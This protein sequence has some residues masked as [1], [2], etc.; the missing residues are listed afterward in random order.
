MWCHTE[1]N[2]LLHLKNFSFVKV[3]PEFENVPTR[4]ILYELMDSAFSTNVKALFTKGS[5]NRYIS[6]TLITQILFHQGVSSND[7]S[8]NNKYIAV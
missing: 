2:T 6:L 7:I 8:L 1:N 3:V 5:H 4:I